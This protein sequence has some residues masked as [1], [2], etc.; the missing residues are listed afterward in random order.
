MNVSWFMG[1][2]PDAG[3]T[4]YASLAITSEGHGV[5]FYAIGLQIAGAR[6][7]NGGD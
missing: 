2:V 1:Q 3:W 5:D 4:S 6:Y 7:V